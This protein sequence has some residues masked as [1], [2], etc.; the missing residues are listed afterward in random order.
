MS[1]ITIE[2]ARLMESLPE[3]EQNFVLEFIKKLVLAWDPDY[4]KLTA[5]EAEALKEAEQSGF[6]DETDIDWSQIGI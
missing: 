6:I 1:N 4:T 5:S 2:A 3:S